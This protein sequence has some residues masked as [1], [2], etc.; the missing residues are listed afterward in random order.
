MKTYR[1]VSGKA[2]WRRSDKTVICRPGRHVA[3]TDD[4]ARALGNQVEL[5]DPP[6]S[7]TEDSG[8]QDESGPGDEDRRDPDER[9]KDAEVHSTSVDDAVVHIKAIPDVAHLQLIAERERRNPKVLGGRKTLLSAIE[10]RI[11]EIENA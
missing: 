4:E 10:A 5:V 9:A 8:Q 6:S 7:S 2:A 11:A 1:V 3:L